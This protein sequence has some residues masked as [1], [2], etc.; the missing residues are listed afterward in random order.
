MQNNAVYYSA[1]FGCQSHPSSGVTN[2]S[3]RYWS[4]FCATTSL[5]RGQAS[6]AT[7]EGGICTKYMTINGDC[8]YSFVFS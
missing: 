2:Y 7:L 5:Q 1:C 3:L 6:L 4:Y 8:N